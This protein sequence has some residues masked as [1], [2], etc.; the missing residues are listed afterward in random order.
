[1]VL[2]RAGQRGDEIQATWIG[3]DHQIA[4]VWQSNSE[5]GGLSDNPGAVWPCPRAS[6]GVYRC[7]VNVDVQSSGAICVGDDAVAHRVD[8]YG[9]DDRYRAALADRSL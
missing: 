9:R 2:A 8:G 4:A 5:H 1:M 3:P 7:T 6:A